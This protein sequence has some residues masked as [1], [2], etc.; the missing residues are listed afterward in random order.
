MLLGSRNVGHSATMCGRRKQSEEE[1]K[2][3]K[4]QGR[5]FYSSGHAIRYET[6]KMMWI[7]WGEKCK[8]ANTGWDVMSRPNV[9]VCKCNVSQDSQPPM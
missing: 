4:T 1:R 7:L 2:V 6:M 5:D 8:C 3:V 9:D